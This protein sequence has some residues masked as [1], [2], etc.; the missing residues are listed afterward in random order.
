MKMLRGWGI[1]DLLCFGVW[2]ER[3]N[4]NY[5]AT[6]DPYGMTNKR[7]DNGKGNGKSNCKVVV[8]LL[9][10]FIR[11]RRGVVRTVG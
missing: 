7:A 4:C 2:F 1:V 6:A 9:V 5:N 10:E 8:V 11:S 3:S